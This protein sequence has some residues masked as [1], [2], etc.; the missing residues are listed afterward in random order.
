M[1]E[2]RTRSAVFP[3][4]VIEAPL[5]HFQIFVLMLSHLPW[6]QDRVDDDSGAVYG[7]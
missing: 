6:V 1:S 3:T 7:L 4:C 2:T 5:K